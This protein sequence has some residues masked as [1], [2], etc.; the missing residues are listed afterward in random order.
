MIRNVN[1]PLLFLE[2]VERVA[3]VIVFLFVRCKP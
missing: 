3:I 1:G 2:I